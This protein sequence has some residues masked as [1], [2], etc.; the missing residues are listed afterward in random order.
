MAG[1]VSDP[2]SHPDNDT[3]ST[4]NAAELVFMSG[5]DPKVD[6]GSAIASASRKH[7]FCYDEGLYVPE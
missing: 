5:C 4:I 3:H 2:G 1:F 6:T 7:N